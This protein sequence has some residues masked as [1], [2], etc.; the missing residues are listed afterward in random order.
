ML[1][2]PQPLKLGGEVVQLFK[3]RSELLCHSIPIVGKF[4]H[5]WLFAA[6]NQLNKALYDHAIVNDLQS[7]FEL[8]WGNYAVGVVL[9]GSVLAMTRLL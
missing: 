4:F 5:I 1:M 3:I 2:L 7:L 8:D 9:T 6:S